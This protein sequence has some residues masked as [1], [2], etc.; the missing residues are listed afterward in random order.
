[1]VE[2]GCDI[3]L[4]ESCAS[5]AGSHAALLVN[6]ASVTR[7]LQSTID[8]LLACGVRVARIFGPQHGIWGDT[9]ANMI[10][11]EGFVHPVHGIPVRSLYGRHRSPEPA[12]LEGLDRVVID[13]PDA[14]ARPYTYLWTA[15]LAVRACAAAGIE[16]VV[17]DRPNPLGGAAVEGAVLDERFRSFVG[18]FPL[19]MRH[20]LTM[21]EALSMI[22]AREGT[23]CALS[24]VRMRGWKREMLFAE[25]GLP[26]VLPSPNMPFPGTAL[27]YPGTVMLEGTNISEGR[28]TTRPFEIVGAPWIEPKAFA[29]ELASAGIAGATFRPLFFT[30]AWDKHAGALCGGVEIHVTDDRAFR[31]VRCGASI[32]A[33]AARLYPARFAWSAPPYE[34]EH[35][36]QPI[37]IIS[38]SASLRE[39]IEARRDLSSLFA[40]WR[41]DEERFMTERAPYLLY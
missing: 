19:P 27:V 3:I 18:L 7:S 2:T 25:T 6:A 36:L 29:A 13:L 38:G 41:G 24:V 12:D 28:G 15:L 10:E 40:A 11:W 31:P 26:W 23:G 14:G 21:G 9:Q 30:P 17:L 22:N 32:V 4:A 34:Y 39:T 37:D 20:G 33:A 5:L 1:V 35:T 8:V 16:V